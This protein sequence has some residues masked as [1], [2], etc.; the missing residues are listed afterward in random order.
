MS[1]FHWSHRSLQ[2]EKQYANAI[3]KINKKGVLC[4][5]QKENFWTPVLLDNFLKT[6]Y[7]ANTVFS[8]SVKETGN[9][10][11]ILLKA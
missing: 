11:P 5:Q 2:I 7:S 6:F 3:M 8:K 1:Y 10:F 4:S 9:G